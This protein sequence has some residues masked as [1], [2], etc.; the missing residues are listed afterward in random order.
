MKDS[1]EI[2][3]NIKE[4]KNEIQNNCVP[5]PIINA[6]YRLKTIITVSIIHYKSEKKRG[7]QSVKIADVIKDYETL[8]KYCN[9]E[10]T[11]K[12]HF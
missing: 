12:S 9:I 4:K 3:Q 10:F 6:Y 7:A 2:I 5:K 11:L 8:E 1:C